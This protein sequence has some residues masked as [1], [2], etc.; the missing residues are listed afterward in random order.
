[1]KANSTSKGEEVRILGFVSGYGKPGNFFGGAGLIVGILGG[2]HVSRSG[3]GRKV[4]G[5]MGLE[6]E[7]GRREMSP[8]PLTPTSVP[9]YYH[10]KWMSKIV[11]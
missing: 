6:E 9:G 10:H 1:M 3:C 4:R 8:L 5:E 11:D 7:E 2:G